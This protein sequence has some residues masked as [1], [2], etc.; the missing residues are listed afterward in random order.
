M[1]TE[2]RYNP[3][4]RRMED[5]DTHDDA[6][7]QALANQTRMQSA[8]GLGN[9]EKGHQAADPN[10]PEPNLKDYQAKF[11][12]GGAEKWRADHN[13][14]MQRQGQNRKPVLARPMPTIGQPGVNNAPQSPTPQATPIAG[15]IQA[16]LGM[17]G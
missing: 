1:P 12:L 10:D 15:L 2:S 16:M 7:A 17:N 4:T 14:W 6:A 9:L 5:F 11:G 13:V 3:N 8:L